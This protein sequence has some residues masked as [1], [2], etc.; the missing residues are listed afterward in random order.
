[1][2]RYQS[3]LD[4]AGIPQDEL[5]VLFH[6]ES[7]EVSDPEGWIHEMPYSREAPAPRRPNRHRNR[8]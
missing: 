4:A 3:P 8:R 1:M 6:E 2:K 5:R 7:R